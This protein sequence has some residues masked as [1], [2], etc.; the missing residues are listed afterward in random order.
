VL[1][2][3]LLDGFRLHAVAALKRQPRRRTIAD[4]LRSTGT[5][6][7]GLINRAGCL[8][9]IGACQLLRPPR[10]PATH[11]LFDPAAH[12]LGA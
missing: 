2:H 5:Q 7:F 4:T 1:A 11:A 6:R 12:A 3:H 8:A 10:V 9:R